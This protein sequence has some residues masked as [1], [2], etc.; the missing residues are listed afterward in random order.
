VFHRTLHQM[1]RSTLATLGPLL[2]A[3]LPKGIT[4]QSFWDL[5]LGYVVQLKRILFHSSL[6]DTPTLQFLNA[7]RPTK[8]IIFLVLLVK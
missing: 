4:V 7:V 8:T 3:T 5:C 6:G 1:N 2:P